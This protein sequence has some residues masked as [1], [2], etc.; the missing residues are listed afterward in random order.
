MFRA[1]G[2][3]QGMGPNP[4]ANL[5]KLTAMAISY[6]VKKVLGTGTLAQI[7]LTIMRNIPMTGAGTLGINSGGSSSGTSGTGSSSGSGIPLEF[8]HR[9][10]NLLC[11]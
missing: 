7:V 3:D 11:R 9:L 4:K 10:L 8:L 5:S 6:L 2:Q 1:N